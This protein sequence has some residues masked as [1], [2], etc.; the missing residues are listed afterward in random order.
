MATKAG[1]EAV[2]AGSALHDPSQVMNPEYHDA[3]EFGTGAAYETTETA[4]A[5]GQTASLY[6]AAMNGF[7][8]PSYVSAE[9]S[10]RSRTRNTGSLYEQALAGE[11]P[12]ARA[13]VSRRQQRMGSAASL[14]GFGDLDVDA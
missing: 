13:P 12:T 8:E 14:S 10:S 5:S 9:E 1:G 2:Y 3:A 7:G 11:T 4:G 6:E